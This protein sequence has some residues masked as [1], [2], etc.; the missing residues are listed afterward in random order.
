[1]EEEEKAS[2]IDRFLKGKLS[3]EDRASFSNSLASDND[4]AEEVRFEINLEQ[5]LREKHREELIKKAAE[6][7]QLAWRKRFRMLS[8]LGLALFSLL[9]LAYYLLSPRLQP[10]LEKEYR[11]K[12]L[13]SI[14]AL[15]ISSQHFGAIAGERDNWKP[16][17]GNS[18]S[19]PN[20]I[21][22]AYQLFELHLKE[23]PICSD[24]MIDFYAA[25]I[26]LYRYEDY[27]RAAELLE[28]VNRN[29]GPDFKAEIQLPL[30]FIELASEQKARARERWEENDFPL[31][32]LPA[33][34][35][36]TFKN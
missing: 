1:M 21:D 14:I 9:A 22:T 35:R 27:P 17:L 31:D 32:T 16:I 19:A 23:N 28:C 34:L 18:L 6:M 11:E 2:L 24:I 25:T 8:I 3:R 12:Q 20:N 29:P 10:L 30:L 4:F 26:A 13:N 33:D 5:R 15:G 36:E 7:D